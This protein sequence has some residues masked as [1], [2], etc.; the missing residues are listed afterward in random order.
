MSFDRGTFDFSSPTA[1]TLRARQGIKW[2]A[3]PDEVL[4]LWVA[5]LDFPTAPVIV[6]E[7]LRAV[8]DESFGYAPSRQPVLAAALA[9]FSQARYNWSY[10]PEAMRILPEV[11][12]GVRVAIEAFSAPGRPVILPVPA[13]MPFFDVIESLGRERIEVPFIDDGGHWVLDLEAVEQ[14]LRSGAGTLLLTSP[15]NPLGKVF[16]NVELVAI[17]ELVEQY[18]ARVVTDE[19]HAPLGYRDEHVPYASVNDASFAHTV[20]LV[21]ASKAWNLPGLC[22]AQAILGSAADQAV[23]DTATGGDTH[24]VSPLGVRAAAAAYRDGR[25]W[26]DALMVQLRRNRDF[27]SAELGAI[28]GLRLIAPEATYLAWLDFAEVDLGAR[29]RPGEGPASYFLREAKVAL[30]PGSS[31]GTR[32]AE[33]LRLNFGTTTAILEQAVEAVLAALPK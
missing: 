17:A 9:D 21:S 27:L 2:N 6:A 16:G 1:Q 14:A 12:T 29:Y 24:G 3:Y 32:S 31:C 22:A 18:G 13:Y 5:E 30:V 28:P 15:H 20:T 4:P 11:L 23:W 10:D 8:R 7:M 26:L 25:P 19:I 33:C